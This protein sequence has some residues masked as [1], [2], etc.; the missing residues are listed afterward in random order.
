MAVETSFLPTNNVTTIEVGDFKLLAAEQGKATT[1]KPAANVEEH[2]DEKDVDPAA[3]F[4]ILCTYVD[5]FGLGAT[6]HWRPQRF[7]LFAYMN[8]VMRAIDMVYVLA[9]PGSQSALLI[10][11][12]QGCLAVVFFPCAKR[13][14]AEAEDSSGCM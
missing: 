2:D 10:A 12:V 3:L 11:I 1:A 9:A 4:Y 13:F 8:A 7:T 6:M 5:I 14:K